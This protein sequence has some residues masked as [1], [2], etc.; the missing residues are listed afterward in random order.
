MINMDTKTIFMLLVLTIVLSLSGCTGVSQDSSQIPRTF[1][2]VTDVVDGDTFTLDSGERVR[3]IGVDTPEMGEEYYAEAT[4]HLTALILNKQVELEG[5]VSNRGHYGRL[6][7]YVWIDG[8]MVNE[9]LVRSGLAE[10]KHYSPDTKYQDILDEAEVKAHDSRLGIWSDTVNFD[11]IDPGDIVHYRDAMQYVGE[12]RTVEGRIV[13]TYRNED[14]GI[15]FLNFND[16]YK[17][18]FT[19][20][21]WSDD[22]DRFPD[23]CEDYYYGKD[24][25]VTG[26]IIEY[27][28][29]PEIEVSDPSQIEV[30]A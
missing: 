28:D 25:L 16:P 19:V 14:A 5:D 24:V 8:M 7:R 13:Q 20:V 21:I 26:K 23:D 1:E 2:N 17:G 30:Q 4:E 12:I 6:L 29:A 18:Y 10:S 11:D 15:I 3:L 9:E 22:W 27:K